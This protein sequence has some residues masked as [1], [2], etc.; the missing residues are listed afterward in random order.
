MVSPFTCDSVFFPDFVLFL[1]HLM[2][3]SLV[4]WSVRDSVSR[5]IRNSIRV[6]TLSCLL[7]TFSLRPSSCTAAAVISASVVHSSFH[8]SRSRDAIEAKREAVKLL[9]P[10]R[11]CL[12]FH[13]VA[14]GINMDSKRHDGGSFTAHLEASSFLHCMFF[15]SHRTF[16][17]SDTLMEWSSW[18]GGR[19]EVNAESTG[20]RERK[21][22]KRKIYKDTAH[23]L[24][25]QYSINKDLC[26]TEW[27][28]RIS[29]QI[30]V[31][32]KR[33]RRKE[34]LMLR[35]LLQSR[36]QRMTH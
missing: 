24:M 7:R 26:Y 22:T 30:T 10:R 21:R 2:L 5:L 18:E 35:V 29:F 12:S 31:T 9:L 11:P 36:E 3:E 25:L 13:F 19:E 17:V 32:V 20:R 8:V 14:F 4:C 27:E 15:D 34:N 6:F 23:T 1:P 16:T 28:E 33:K